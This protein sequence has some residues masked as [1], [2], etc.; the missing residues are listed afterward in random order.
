MPALGPA[1]T[2]AFV[3]ID[4]HAECGTAA[5]GFVLESQRLSLAYAT[6]RRAHRGHTRGHGRPYL[7]HPVQVAELLRDQGYDEDV[8]IAAL[9]HD[10]IEDSGLTVENVTETF[11]AQVA[12]LVAALTEDP[13]IEDWEERKSMLR[14]AIAA[15]GPDAAAICVADKLANLHDWRLVYAEVGERSVEFFKAPTLAARIRA[16]H[17]DLAMGERIAPG[18]KLNGQLRR[19]LAQFESERQA[20]L[21]GVR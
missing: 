2:L 9:L 19:E 17:A 8:C 6:A 4:L 15:Y 13:A 3:S 18:L 20:A 16:W 12:A 1:H 21:N 7:E 11:G 5:P 10:V 14:D